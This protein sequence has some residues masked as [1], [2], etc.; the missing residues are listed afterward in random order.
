MLKIKENTMRDIIQVYF[1][2][3]IITLRYDSKINYIS[4]L[5]NVITY[6]LMMSRETGFNE[7]K[8][9]PT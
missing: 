6:N 9:T 1:L 7:C 4:Y 2:T 8:V 5:W 3:K